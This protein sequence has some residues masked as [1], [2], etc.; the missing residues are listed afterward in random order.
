MPRTERNLR[1]SHYRERLD[2]SRQPVENL[3]IPYYPYSD[4]RND[5]AESPRDG[6]LVSWNAS[7]KHEQCPGPVMISGSVPGYAFCPPNWG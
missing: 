2:F 3:E 1:Y 4:M 6:S 5:A 7:S